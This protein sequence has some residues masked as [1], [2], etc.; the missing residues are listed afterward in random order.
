MFGVLFKAF[1]RVIDLTLMPSIIGFFLFLLEKA[2]GAVTWVLVIIGD[3]IVGAL[4]WAL[5]MIDLPDISLD[6]STFGTKFLDIA[7]V[8][9]LWPAMGV[10]FSIA[11][12][13]FVVRIVTLGVVGSK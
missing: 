5:G 7:S 4:G 6:A 11:I 3:L 10:Y 9:G 8:V 2:L 13:A 12:V 1:K